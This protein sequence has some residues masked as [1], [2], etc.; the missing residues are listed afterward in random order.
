MFGGLN[1][2][3]YG[4]EWRQNMKSYNTAFPNVSGCF[5]LP[6]LCLYTIFEFTSFQARK[7]GLGPREAKRP[8]Y[9]SGHYNLT[10]GQCIS[11]HEILMKKG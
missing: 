8:R 6:M 3:H 4:I 9:G 5:I 1:D 10:M 7:W 2:S 11:Y